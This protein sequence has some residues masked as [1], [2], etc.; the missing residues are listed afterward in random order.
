MELWCENKKLKPL[1]D[2]KLL[3]AVHEFVGWQVW[4]GLKIKWKVE[5]N[6]PFCELP[7][8]AGSSSPFVWQDVAITLLSCLLMEK[9][10]ATL[11]AHPNNLKSHISY[12]ANDQQMSPTERERALTSITLY[13]LGI[14]LLKVSRRATARMFPRMA[15]LA[16]RR[17]MV[18]R[19]EMWVCKVQAAATDQACCATCCKL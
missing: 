5:V 3:I 18:P 17:W 13:F 2:A 16:K 6:V 8:A 7:R 4:Q 12:W 11:P 15:A 14:V 1:S 19:I 9:Q 10:W